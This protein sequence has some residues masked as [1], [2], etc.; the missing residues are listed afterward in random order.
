MIEI[1]FV[2]ILIIGIGFDQ[3]NVHQNQLRF[4]FV[5][6]WIRFKSVTVPLLLGFFV[7]GF[8]GDLI[9]FNNAVCFRDQPVNIC[10]G[11]CEFRII[12]TSK[13]VQRVSFK[14]YRFVGCG[15][16]MRFFAIR[17]Y[18]ISTQ[19]LPHL[20]QILPQ[21]LILSLIIYSLSKWVHLTS[22]KIDSMYLHNLQSTDIRPSALNF[23]LSCWHRN[24][25]YYPL[26][27][28]RLK[29]GVKFG[30]FAPNNNDTVAFWCR[31][32]PQNWTELLLHYGATPSPNLAGNYRVNLNWDRR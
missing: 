4:V 3:D 6:S 16:S 10:H 32:C 20:K 25:H 1:E 31:L 29:S 22:I 24:N 17:H 30:C 14:I 13:N 28:D 19:V 2:L 21:E 8:Y 27:I 11:F 15:F 23:L 12:L 9:Y 5:R 18:T 7:Y 26:R